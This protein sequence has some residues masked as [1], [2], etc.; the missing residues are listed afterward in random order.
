MKK[1]YKIQYGKPKKFSFF[2][3]F[4]V[5]RQIQEHAW[6]KKSAVASG[7]QIII[8]LEIKH[9]TENLIF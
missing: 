7:F 4:K 3:T 5:A 6:T 2:C 1:W 8:K 9:K